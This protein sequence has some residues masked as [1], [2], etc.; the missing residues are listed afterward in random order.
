MDRIKGSIGFDHRMDEVRYRFR[1]YTGSVS[2]GVAGAQEQGPT[3]SK[4]DDRGAQ[5]LP[6]SPSLRVNLL[7]SIMVVL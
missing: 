3:C 6:H 2:F 5:P 4:N 7:I 1:R